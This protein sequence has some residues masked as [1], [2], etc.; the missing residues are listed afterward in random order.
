MEKFIVVLISLKRNEPGPLLA[1]WVN[2]FNTWKKKKKRLTNHHLNKLYISKIEYQFFL[3]NIPC[4]HS[5]SHFNCRSFKFGTYTQSGIGMFLSIC[6]WYIWVG[7]TRSSLSSLDKVQKHLCSLVGDELVSSLQSHVIRLLLFP[8]RLLFHQF[9][10][11]LLK[12]T[13]WCTQRQAIVILFIF[14]W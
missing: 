8:N 3:S 2:N 10:P 14:Q 11:L 9:R 6:C 12:P 5:F 1:W 4:F 7:A 13:M